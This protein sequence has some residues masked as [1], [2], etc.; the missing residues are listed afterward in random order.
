MQA[1][2]NPKACGRSQDSNNTG[3]NVGPKIEQITSI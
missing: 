2:Q 1:F 3:V